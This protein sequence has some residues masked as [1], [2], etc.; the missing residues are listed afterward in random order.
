MRV[1]LVG[2]G[3]V[4]GSIALIAARRDFFELMVVA[5]FDAA[6]AA[7]VAESTGDARFVAGPDRRLRLPGRGGAARRTSL[8]RVDERHRSA[9]RD[10]AVP[11]RAGRRRQLPGHGDVAVAAASDRPLRSDRGQTRRRT[12]RARRAVGTAGPTRAG[13]DGHRARHG[14]RLRPVRGGRV[15]LRDRGTRCPGRGQ[16]RRRRL[17]LRAELLDLDDHRG[18]P[19]PAGDLR[20][21]P[22]LVHH[23]RRSASRRS[24]SS[25]TASARSNASTSST[26]RCC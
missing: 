15:V 12:V 24:S 6:R 9:L 22:R 17:R 7:Q 19:Q 2:A 10:A 26:K 3:G 25:R 8:R 14:R 23:R 20:E 5:D 21:G 4:G 18:V 1:L 13:R 11:G 16:P